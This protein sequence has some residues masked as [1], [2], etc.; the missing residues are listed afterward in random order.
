MLLNLHDIQKHN[1]RMA[2]LANELVTTI[3][4]A[5]NWVWVEKGF[6][7]ELHKIEDQKKLFY[8]KAS[9]YAVQK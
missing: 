5:E 6:I 2:L 8:N 1:L 3:L 7:T 4:H 9:R